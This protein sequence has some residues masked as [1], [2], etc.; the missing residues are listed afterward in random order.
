[1]FEIVIVIAFL[2]STSL[3]LSSVF[4]CKI[5]SG[6]KIDN[7][8][9]PYS[10]YGYEKTSI[11]MEGLLCE[12]RDEQFQFNY[13]MPWPI[14]KPIDNKSLTLGD[15]CKINKHLR[16]RDV[17]EFRFHRNFV[18][19]KYFNITNLLRY[20]SYF[21]FPTSAIFVNL[22][23][24]ELDILNDSNQ[25]LSIIPYENVEFVYCIKCKID[26]YSNGRLIQTC[27]DIIDS[28]SNNNSL[29]LSL[30]QIERNIL[31]GFKMF[32]L[33]AQFKTRLC[34]LVF[35]NSNI[36][37]FYLSGLSD[38]FYKK[39]ILKIENKTFIDLNSNIE[40]LHFINLNNINID[41]N[42]L[43]PSVF[44]NTYSV[45]ISGQVNMIDGNSL[46]ALESLHIIVFF[47]D[48]YRDMIHKNGIKWIRDLNP[49]LNV[50]LSNSN[51]IKTSD[52]IKLKMIILK[53]KSSLSNIHLS[54][55]FPDEDF[56][57]YKDFPFNQLVSVLE[58]ADDNI[59]YEFFNST[60]QY[61]TCT[62][63]WVAQYFYILFNKID[64]NR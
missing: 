16:L 57:L 6:C 54:K 48:S 4:N 17:I 34:P 61:Y 11:E 42:L 38:M 18:L 44:Q 49:D 62:Y 13:L 46:N 60:R 21:R 26:F 32:L 5:P 50:N 41:A 53:P 15:L 39:N 28:N 22:N 9:V 58:F 3:V 30:F 19:N 36:S 29:I 52:F 43:N 51:E 24:F 45:Y 64:L 8:H 10:T 14:L 56:C 59:L 37:H 23:G 40:Y 35:K 25:H 33:D 1:M 63:L 47:K 7:V 27:Q 20:F 2:I 31:V 55:L 12:I